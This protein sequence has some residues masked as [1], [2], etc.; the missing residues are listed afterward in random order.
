MK[1]MAALPFRWQ[2]AA[3]DRIGRWIGKLARRRRRIA[4]IN[5]ALC[6]PEWSAAERAALL[7]AHFAALGIGLF[8][9]ALAW[10]CLLYTSRCV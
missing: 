5:L 9:T 8:E 10:F 4:A 6:F 3:G 7:E 2:L 1:L